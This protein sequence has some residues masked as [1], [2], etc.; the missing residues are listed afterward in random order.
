MSNIHSSTHTAKS[1]LLAVAF[2]AAATL[3]SLPVQAALTVPNVPL[4]SGNVVEPNIWFILDDSGSMAPDGGWVMENPALPDVVGGDTNI[5]NSTYTSNVVFYDPRKTYKTWQNW[6]KSYMPDTPYDKVFDDLSLAIDDPAV[7]NDVI[8]LRSAD[9]TWYAPK[10]GATDLADATQYYRWR[11]LAGGAEATRCERTFTTTWGWRNCVAVTSFTWTDEDGNTV[12]RDL[13]AEKLNFAIWYSFHRTRM[14][15]AKAGSSYAFS[16]LPQDVRVGFTTIWDRNKFDIPV[17]SDNGR[18]RNFG[19]STNRSTWFARLFGAKGSGVTPLIPALSR[20]GEMYD[21]T[22]ATSPWGPETGSAQLACRQNF[23]I[24]TTDGFWNSGTTTLGNADNSD[25]VAIPNPRGG[26]YTYTPVAPFKDEYS[27]TLA[28]VAMHYWKTDLRTLDNI[29]PTT[30]SNPAFWQHMVTFGISIGLRGTLDPVTD[31]PGLI[32]GTTQWPDPIN[33]S[34]LERIDDLLH[35]AVNGHGSFVAASDPEQFTKGLRN[36]LNAI[37]ERTASGSNVA[38]NTVRLDSETR[39]F[40][41]SYVAGKWTGE[42]ASYPISSAGV[43]ATPDWLGSLGIPTTGRK[44]FTMYGSAKSTFPH[45]TQQAALGVNEAAYIAGA[46]NNEIR[47]GGTFRTRPHL[48]GDIINSSPAFVKETNTIF[49]GANDGM[50]HAFASTGSNKGDELFAYIPNATS[51]ASLARLKTLTDPNYAHQYFVDGPVVVSSY[52]DTPNK[53]ILVG[54]LGRG[55]KGVYFLDVTNPA[56]FS[57][58]NII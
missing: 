49:V 50:L 9:R 51:S 30:P 58:S 47:N 34:G 55:G 20:A 21:D 4:Q 56:A 35:A 13:D 41:A 29:V 6:D 8:D 46:T 26:S 48:L 43:S 25:G 1:R 19:A 45:A 38:A 28:D 42:L 14:K 12:T 5:G 11:I 2:S 3:M 54:A 18:F 10:P 53:N 23:T 52:A 15:V 16:D 24:L 44:V 27:N 32:A 22:G 33:N 36:A 7:A 17:G 40:Q 39:I 57:A 37:V 31:M